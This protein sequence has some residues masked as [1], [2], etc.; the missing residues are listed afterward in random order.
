[1]A[2]QDLTVQDNKDVDTSEGLY[3]KLHIHDV[4]IT[5]GYD[6]KTTKVRIQDELVKGNQYG[7][8]IPNGTSEVVYNN[9]ETQE[10]FGP[11]SGTNE[12]L[13]SF[14]VTLKIPFIDSRFTENIIRY[15]VFT[16]K[17]SSLSDIENAKFKLVDNSPYF[18]KVARAFFGGIN[19][20]L[21]TGLLA[22]MSSLN[23]R[24]NPKSF[25]DFANNPWSLYGRSASDIQKVL[26]NNWILGKYG[27]TGQGWKV[28]NKNHPNQQIYFNS[29]G[30]HGGRY[31]G[32]K[33]FKNGGGETK[34]TNKDYIHSSDDKATVIQTIFE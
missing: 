17:V 32:I 31:W 19:F 6:E 24:P 9:T 25:N 7:I 3:T 8:S 5:L 29:N 1:M 20:G 22:N 30:R 15:N 18:M 34:I 28:T 21:N 33:G 14:N 16:A 26:G 23:F 2:L 10:V 11:K 12:T 13:E 27:K 4:T